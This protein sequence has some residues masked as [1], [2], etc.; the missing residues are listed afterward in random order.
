MLDTN[1]V[2]NT[3]TASGAD[4]KTGVN[5]SVSIKGASFSTSNVQDCKYIPYVAEQLQVTTV[6][7]TATAST[8]YSFN[9]QYTDTLMGVVKNAI[10]TG[11]TS[12]ATTS[13]TLISTAAVAFINAIGNRSVVA[14]LSGDDFTITSL[15]GYPEHNFD[16]TG[17][18][19]VLTP[20]VST[21]GIIGTGSGTLLL[22]QMPNLA[23][24]GISASNNYD[25]V[26]VYLNNP[27]IGTYVNGNINQTLNLFVK[28]DASNVK[29]FI[30]YSTT[31][32]MGYGTFT[33]AVFNNK[34]ATYSAV[35]AN[36]A[37]ASSVATRASGS[38]FT[39]NIKSGDLFL[40]GTT[41]ALINVP[42]TDGATAANL[43]FTN[44]TVTGS[45]VSSDAALLVKF[46]D[47]PA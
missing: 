18:A 33:A 2:Y 44:A 37:V 5:G 35:G 28:T 32:N 46:T 42:Y 4:C 24:A 14:A 11:Y 41:P 47:L 7:P 31:L 9:L 38:F 15:T 23:D 3:V 25:Q 16:A 12:G 8:S 10:W 6:V 13:K 27:A 43:I 20:T 34:L 39:E 40:I 30:G 19:G 29:S 17:S 36:V 45:D 26:V 22:A 21:A 1:V